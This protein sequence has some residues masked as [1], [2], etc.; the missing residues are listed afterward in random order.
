M[1]RSSGIVGD[2]VLRQSPRSEDTNEYGA[3]NDD[4]KFVD[5]RAM[6]RRTV[7]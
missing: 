3:K 4:E 1:S 2:G 5:D 6:N 7:N